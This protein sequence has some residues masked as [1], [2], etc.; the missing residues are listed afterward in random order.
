MNGRDDELAVD[1]HQREFR[2]TG[3]RLCGGSSIER[4]RKLACALALETD[5]TGTLFNGILSRILPVRKTKR[6]KASAAKAHRA[7]GDVP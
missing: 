7:K 2:E 5:Q 1:L 4:A 3:Y 6:K